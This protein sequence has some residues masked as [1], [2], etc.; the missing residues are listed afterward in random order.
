M[1]SA[2]EHITRRVRAWHGVE[3][4]PR[5]TVN[6]VFLVWG[7]GVPYLLLAD[8]ARMHMDPAPV[9]RPQSELVAEGLLAC[10]RQLVVNRA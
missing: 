9:V 4:N 2:V 7:G 5:E 6:T 10:N 3:R 8:R 1:G